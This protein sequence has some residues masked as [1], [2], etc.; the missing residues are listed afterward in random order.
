MQIK[1]ENI[2]FFLEFD[3]VKGKLILDRSRTFNPINLEYGNERTIELN[4]N[5]EL[6]LTIYVD[7]SV[8]EIFINKGQKVMTTTYYP[9]Q[10]QN[11]LYLQGD[12]AFILTYY[13]LRKTN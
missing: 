12:K 11:N 9:E 13:P 6:N 4:K 2:S 5:E 7:Q 8:C 10:G 1:I 3:T